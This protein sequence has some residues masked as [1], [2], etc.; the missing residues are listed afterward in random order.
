VTSNQTNWKS[1]IEEPQTLKEEP[2][3]RLPAPN[4]MARTI[5]AIMEGTS[6]YWAT[7]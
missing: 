6:P 5:L 4:V 3:L 2:A 1:W 7:Q